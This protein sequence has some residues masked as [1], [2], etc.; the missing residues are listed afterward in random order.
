[1][2]KFS[3]SSITTYGTCPRKYKLRYVEKLR[4]TQ[5]SSAL[6]FGGAIDK[7]LNCLLETRDAEKAKKVFEASWT[8]QRLFTP[9]GDKELI[10]KFC[11]YID[12]SSSDFDLELLDETSRFKLATHEEP[13]KNITA[14]QI[15]KI[16]DD[17][18]YE[19]LDGFQRKLYNYACWLTLKH[20]GLVMLDSYNTKIMPQIKK[21]LKVQHKNVL[22][23]DEGDELE[24]YLDAIVEWEDGSV[25][26]LDNKTSARDYDNDSPI[27]SAQ[28]I[29]Y[30]AGNKEE[31]DLTA[32]GF[33]VL[34]KHLNK[35]KK[36]VCVECFYDGT[37][38]RYKTCPS[39]REGKRCDG[40]WMEA[41]SPECAIQT[42]IKPVPE[43]AEEFVMTTFADMANGIKSNDFRANLSSCK[44]GGFACEYMRHCWYG[45]KKN[46]LNKV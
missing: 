19:A 36:K 9:N 46:L 16:K 20:K 6:L 23:N 41:I 12:Y 1:M 31:F 37:G 26:L 35:N 27:M 11:P 24:Q 4:P 45:E 30:Y 2:A 25:V 18:G 38:E 34:K 33:I 40:M 10:L 14:A 17:K 28:L 7:G 39:I 44:Q 43:V 3:Y 32:V 21:V 22:A 29:S 8:R 42:I 13:L 5:T 15:A